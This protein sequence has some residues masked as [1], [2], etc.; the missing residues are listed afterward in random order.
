MAIA[1]KVKNYLER[2]HL[3]FEVVMHPYTHSSRRAA[4]MAG[5]PS[6]RM[7]K[8]VLLEDDRGYVMAVLP[9]SRQV[10]LGLLGEQMGRTLSLASEDEVASV[11]S[12]CAVGAIPPLGM[13][14][15]MEMICDDSLMANAEIY[16]EAGDHE[17]LIRMGRDDFMR[18]CTSARRGRF[19]H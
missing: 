10:H 2:Q 8:A 19:C 15:G 11:F 3:P 9:A 13:A 5:V 18:I 4:E 7:A 12:D 14:Y 6:E 1:T 17:E 16:F